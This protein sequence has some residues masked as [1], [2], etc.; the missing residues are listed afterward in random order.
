MDFIPGASDLVKVWNGIATTVPFLNKLFVMNYPLLGG[1]DG[2]GGG[3]TGLIGQL[4]KWA[5]RLLS[6]LFGAALVLRLAGRG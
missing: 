4:I 3:I 2:E 1:E 5:G 6:I